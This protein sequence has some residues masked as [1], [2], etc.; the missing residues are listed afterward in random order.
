M[1][2]LFFLLFFIPSLALANPYMG[3][4]KSQYEATYKLMMARQSGVPLPDMLQAVESQKPEDFDILTDS[5]LA[6]FYEAKDET[7][8][9]V[10]RI[11][12]MP[13]FGFM[14]SAAHTMAA[15]F[16]NHQYLRCTRDKRK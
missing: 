5:E 7:I 3:S 9:I 2:P 13:N 8:R 14:K 15:E 11:Y 1:K 4:C 6:L 10:E 12:S 16:A